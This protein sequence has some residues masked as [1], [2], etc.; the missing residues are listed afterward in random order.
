MTTYPYVPG[1]M[2]IPK[3]IQRKDCPSHSTRFA[4]PL[5]KHVVARTAIS[6]T[7]VKVV[8]PG[9]PDERPNAGAFMEISGDQDATHAGH[10]DPSC[11]S[12]VGTSPEPR[13]SHRGQS[14]VEETVPSA[15]AARTRS[16]YCD[17][18]DNTPA[19]LKPMIVDRV[20]SRTPF[21]HAPTP[22]STS[23]TRNGRSTDSAKPTYHLSETMPG[24]SGR[25]S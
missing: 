3:T 7:R 25:G 10:H 12:S 1:L 16:D 22:G 9:Q 6:W 2:K 11:R 8:P 19:K 18:H 24:G 15:R 13:H 21:S 14:A 23:P 20:K 4:R 5:S 17:V